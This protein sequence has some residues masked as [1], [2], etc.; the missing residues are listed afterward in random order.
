LLDAMVDKLPIDVIVGKKNLEVRPAHTHKGEIVK[1]LTYQHADVDFLICVGDD[2]TDEDMFR[3]VFAIE[4]TDQNGTLTVTPPPSLTVF[5]SLAKT[6]DPKVINST[7]AASTSDGGS[8]A[9]MQNDKL[10][11]LPMPSNLKSENVFTV[12]IIPNAARKTIAKWHLDEP[13]DLLE[14]LEVLAQ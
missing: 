2:K 1:R 11:L 13:A 6:L 7:G 4:S 10:E 9:T 14:I 12:G 8:I 5:S 3:A